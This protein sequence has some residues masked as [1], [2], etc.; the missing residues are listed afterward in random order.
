M[1][2]LCS[3]SGIVTN[4]VSISSSQHQLA[5]VSRHNNS[6]DY[7]QTI[8]HVHIVIMIVLDGVMRAGMRG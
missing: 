4:D 1:M 6:E 8:T 5:Y 7:K 3:A 2:R